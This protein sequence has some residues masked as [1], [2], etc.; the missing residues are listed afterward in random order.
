MNAPLIDWA[1]GRIDGSPFPRVVEQE[2]RIR[3][4]TRDNREMAELC[5]LLEAELVAQNGLRVQLVTAQR[6]R[7]AALEV[8]NDLLAR[9]QEQEAEIERLRAQLAALV[10]QRN[11]LAAAATELCEDVARREHD[12]RALKLACNVNRVVLGI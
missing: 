5:N 12:G 3:R 11:R 8:A 6:E 9:C 4:I 1:A 7:D 10:E 2:E